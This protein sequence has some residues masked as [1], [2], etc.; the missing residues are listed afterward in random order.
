MKAK[1]VKIGGRYSLTM[2]I[3]S[4]PGPLEV[5]TA[6]LAG[7]GRRY[8]G[9]IV[10]ELPPGIPIDVDRIAIIR[11]PG[12]SLHQGS[13]P[14]RFRIRQ[15]PQKQRVHHAENRGVRADAQCEGEDDDNGKTRRS[16]TTVSMRNVGRGKLSAYRVSLH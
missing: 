8:G 13:Q 3:L 12:D 4:P 7:N 9:N 16:S 15:R 5:D 10:A 14:L 6:C 2:N 1:D 11:R